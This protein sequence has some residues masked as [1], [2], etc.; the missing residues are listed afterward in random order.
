ML[1]EYKYTPSFFM[2]ELK[3][4]LRKRGKTGTAVIDAHG[5]KRKSAVP[6]TKPKK[7]PKSTPPS[8]DDQ[9]ASSEEVEEIECEHPKCKRVFSSKGGMKTHMRAHLQKKKNP[10][11]IYKETDHADPPKQADRNKGSASAGETQSAGRAPKQDGGEVTCP[12]CP[13]KFPGNDMLAFMEHTKLHKQGT[14]PEAQLNSSPPVLKK[15]SENDGTGSPGIVNQ[16]LQGVPES[17]VFP[18]AN[19]QSIS[20]YVAALEF[21]HRKK[22]LE[23]QHELENRLLSSFNSGFQP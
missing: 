17:G 19:G 13:G 9:E 16:L 23:Q 11:P 1:V 21:L 3:R 15:A 12:Y 8:S 18:P 20:G 7:V 14:P 10:P 6:E 5:V 22:R 2:R 4:G